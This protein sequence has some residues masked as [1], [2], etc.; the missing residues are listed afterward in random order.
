MK[1]TRRYVGPSNL[2]SADFFVYSL[3]F[4]NHWVKQKQIFVDHR[5]IHQFSFLQYSFKTRFIFLSVNLVSHKQHHSTNSITLYGKSIYPMF[6]QTK[7]VEFFVPV[8]SFMTEKGRDR[9]TVNTWD[10]S[11]SSSH[12][13]KR[14]RFKLKLNFNVFMCAMILRFKDEKW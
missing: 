2:K 8:M 3:H 4:G 9:P 10:T 7:A 1:S 13:Y 14:L 11:M 12:F 5:C 6:G